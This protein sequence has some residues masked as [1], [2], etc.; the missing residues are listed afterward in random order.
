MLETEGFQQY[1]HAIVWPLAHAPID[2][3]AQLVY[4]HARGVD[5]QIGRIHQRLEQPALDGNGLVQVL[6]MATQRVLAARF[7][8]AAQ[9]LLV[10]RH[11]EYQLAL[12]AAA[13]ELVEQHRHGRDLIAGV[14]R[15]DADRGTLIDRRAAADRVR[16]EWLEQ[17]RRDVV[18]AVEVQIL[19]HVQRHALAGSG[20]AA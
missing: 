3:F 16:D 11:Q 12:D 7:R 20:Q 9:Q 19:E 8:E 15:V 14:A 17:R 1:R 13:F 4:P 2:Q 10:A 5:H 6:S 18:D